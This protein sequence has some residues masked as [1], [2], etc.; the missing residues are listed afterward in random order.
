M[1]TNNSWNSEDPAQVARGN[2]GLS[3]TTA[4]AVICGG[5]TSTSDFQSIASVG[6]SGQTLQSNGAALPTFQD[7]GGG[8]WSLISTATASSSATIE[9][10]NLTSTHFMFL[11]VGY[12]V[13]A[14]TNEVVFHFRTSTDNGVSFD[15]SAGNY[16][17]ISRVYENTSNNIE[18]AS[19]TEIVI[20]GGAANLIG[21]V[22]AETLDFSC[23]LYN[24]SST[25]YT[26]INYGGAY[27]GSGS[28]K[29]A[30]FGGGQR[31]SA[32]DVDAI[33]FLM[34]SGN[35]ASGTFKLYGLSAS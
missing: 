19:A 6:T 3:S 14:A 5:T 27:R 16:A 17:H 28:E 9:F 11:I 13:L 21:N 22:A 25:A 34:S 2:T 32:A 26:R 10:N 1:T 24:P 23:W 30:F 20:T 15:S 8:V 4:Y 31:A 7:A 12:A 18:S 29:C 33:Q 35:I